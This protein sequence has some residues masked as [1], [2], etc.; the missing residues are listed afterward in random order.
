MFLWQHSQCGGA[1]VRE[2]P[3]TPRPHLAPRRFVFYFFYEVFVF[4]TLVVVI[5][6]ER[7]M[8]VSFHE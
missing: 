1:E 5:V 2:M 6:I 8:C 7:E 4:L 3:A